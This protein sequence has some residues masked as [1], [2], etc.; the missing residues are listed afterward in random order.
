M[1]ETNEH[2]KDGHEHE[3]MKFPL[4]RKIGDSNI[5]KFLSATEFL[6]VVVK[7]GVQLIS[8]AAMLP[9]AWPAFMEQSSAAHREE[10]LQLY[11]RVWN[12]L[13]KN[14]YA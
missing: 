12:S 7:D 6:N 9:A 2:I 8:S 3:P 4:Y 10:W 5:Y 11:A 13:D 14:A 1:S